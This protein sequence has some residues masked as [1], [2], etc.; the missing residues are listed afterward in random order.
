MDFATEQAGKLAADRKAKAGAAIFAA[1]AGIRLLEGF[2]DQLLLVLR[3]A[4]TGVG[5]F[6]GHYGRRVIENRMF[7]A[8]AA[9]CGRDAEA[10]AAFGGELE[11]VGE[12]VLQHLLQPLRVGIDA[13]PEMRIDRDVEGELAIFGFVA[14]RPSDGF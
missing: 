9:K 12:Q 4:D 3:N 11:G 10:N 14:E 5:Y 7:S 13:S 6:E 8:P 1:G 2:E